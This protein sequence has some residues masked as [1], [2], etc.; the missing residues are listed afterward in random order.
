VPP[1]LLAFCGVA[2]VLV[3]TPGP[4]MALIARNALVGGRS[5]VPVTV[6]GICAGIVVHALAAAIGLSALLKASATAYAVVKL[7]GGA[8]LVFLG[9]QAWR[10]SMGRA[11]EPAGQ[12]RTGALLAGRAGILGG[13]LTAEDAAAAPSRFD[14]G[15]AF[16]QGFISNVLNPK[17]VVF[18]ISVLPQFTSGSGSFFAQVLV[19]G[20]AFEVLTIVWLLA[21][22]SAMARVGDALRRPRIRHLLERLTGTIL[23]A[24]GLRVATDGASELA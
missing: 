6:L 5:A 3:I 24:L 13:E 10:F 18:F 11:S 15:A 12:P 19:L 8:Y 1:E 21:Y 16:R 17:L 2:A 22:G 4:D 9:I 20:A 23:I 14:A 7:L